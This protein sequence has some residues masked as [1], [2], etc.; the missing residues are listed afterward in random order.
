MRSS[1]KRK[2]NS[3]EP[4]APSLSWRE[5]DGCDSLDGAVRAIVAA[6]DFSRHPYFVWMAAP[7]TNVA[8]FRKSQLPFRFAVESFS[9]SLAAVLARIP[10]LEARLAVADNVAEEHG[11]GN[12]LASHKRTFIQYLRAL[13]AT[14]SDLGSDC[15]VTVSAFNH[16][17]LDYCLAQP[18][19]SG[20]ALLGIIEQLY[21][22]ISGAIAETVAARGWAAHGTQRHYEVHRSL[23]A[24]H[25]EQLFAIARSTWR[26]PS[27]R[28]QTAQALLL[29]AHW[30][31][32]LYRDLLPSCAPA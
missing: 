26:E 24:D 32:Q 7:R 29:G 5:L 27:A 4:A 11:R 17:L 21:V 14:T 23:D 20:A 8:E 15:P 31:W 13:G 25:A 2:R 12:Q 18:H 6:Y 1:A 28:A 10:R 3:A 19:P 30:F 22:W 9:Q 16:A